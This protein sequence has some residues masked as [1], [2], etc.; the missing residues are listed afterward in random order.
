MTSTESII[1]PQHNNRLTTFLT[2]GL[3]SGVAAAFLNLI[4]MYLHKSITSF[5]IPGVINIGSVALASLIPG[6]ISGIY[7]FI[8]R[9]IMTDKNAL[10]TF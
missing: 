1:L 5:S 9:R 6:I 10:V 8:L 2:T 3:I 4:Y 7:Y